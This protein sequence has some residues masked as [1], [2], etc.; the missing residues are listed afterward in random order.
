MYIYSIVK[1]IHIYESYSAVNDKLVAFQK[2]NI[3]I[4]HYIKE[5]KQDSSRQTT[6]FLM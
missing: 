4:G 3:N 6:F 5:N 2:V 1:F